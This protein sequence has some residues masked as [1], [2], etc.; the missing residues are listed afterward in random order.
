MENLAPYVDTTQD[1]SEDNLADA[2]N[3]PFDLPGVDGLAM[4]LKTCDNHM[5]NTET[6]VCPDHSQNLEEGEEDL[7]PIS[8]TSTKDMI[9]QDNLAKTNTD[10]LGFVDF[11]HQCVGKGMG[12]VEHNI[13]LDPEEPKMCNEKTATYWTGGGME[14]LNEEERPPSKDHQMDVDW[15]LP[16]YLTENHAQHSNARLYFPLQKTL[17]NLRLLDL[18]LKYNTQQAV[19]EN[20]PCE[21]TN[22]SGSSSDESD[23]KLPEQKEQENSEET[24]EA[25][26]ASL[27]EV[28]SQCHIKLEEMEELEHYSRQLENTLWEA[29]NTIAY[30][31]ETVAALQRENAQKDDEI[32]FLSEELMESNRM[33]HEKSEQ[34]TDMNAMFRNLGH[35]LENSRKQ[36]NNKSTCPKHNGQPPISENPQPRSPSHSKICIIL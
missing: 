10:L 8:E 24:E 26:N 21:A 9:H 25:H 32:I 36:Q 16:Y 4:E 17:R 34:I 1:P 14:S 15:S 5:I 27:F 2:K 6:E 3:V 30:L 22:D 12:D 31:K 20:K 19:L 18:R 33:L 11:D 28:L 13:C 23:S 7:E 35:H 29:Q